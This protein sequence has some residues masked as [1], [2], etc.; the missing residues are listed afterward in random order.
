[1]VGLDIATEA[2]RCC[3]AR[4]LRRLVRASAERL[5]VAD[6]SCHLITALGLIEHVEDDAQ[7]VGELARVCRPGGYV[8]LLTSAYRAL[9]SRHDDLVHHKRRYTRRGLKA[10]LT[11]KEFE[12]VKLSYVNMFLLPAIVGFRL[13]RSLI[14]PRASSSHN[15]TP[16]MFQPSEPINRLLYAILR[17]EQGLLRYVELPFGVGL[18]ALLRRTPQPAAA[19]HPQPGELVGANP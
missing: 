1:V 2:L 11:G 7:F 15:G 13:L 12:I 14:S 4:G 9:W 17:V 3:Q 10:L 8:L 16:D 6:G 5:P 18:V 19:A